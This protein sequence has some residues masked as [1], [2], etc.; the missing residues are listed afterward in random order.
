ML[1]RLNT[2]LN[3]EAIKSFRAI[4]EE[5]KKKENTL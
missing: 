1:T 4:K 5:E 3:M 2:I